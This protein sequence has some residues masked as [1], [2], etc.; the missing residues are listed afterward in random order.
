M[1][2]DVGISS[3]CIPLPSPLRWFQIRWEGGSLPVIRLYDAPDVFGGV[4]EFAARNTSTE[5]EVA[6]GD[7]V[8]LDSVREV[9]VALGHGANEDA[10]ALILAEA[11]DVVA[12]SNNLG[13]EAES[14]L[15]AVRRKVVGDWV[16]DD[17]DELLLGGGRA[18]L[19]AME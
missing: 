9:V 15:P 6:D 7:G 11:L 19:V 10:Y 18:D 17:L 4:A 14:N 8:V 3:I 13:V 16:L 1:A 2:F 5:I 12:H